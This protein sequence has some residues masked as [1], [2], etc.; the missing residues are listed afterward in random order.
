MGAIVLGL[1]AGAICFFFCTTVKNALGYDDSLDVFGVHCVGGIIG[2]LLT[3]ILVNP[4]LGGAGIMDYTTGKIAD[5]DLV[6]QMIAQCKAVLTTL[7]WSGVGSFVLFKIVD[8]LV[9]LRVSVEE[10]RE[11]LDISEHGERAYTM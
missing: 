11:G 4:A 1:I 3:G 9:G 6:V 5:Y 2:A 7:V 8:L 10:E